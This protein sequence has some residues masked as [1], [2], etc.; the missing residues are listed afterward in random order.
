[1]KGFATRTT[2]LIFLLAFGLT[3][4]AWAQ[5]GK[6]AGRVT[7]AATGDPL[8]GVNVLLAGTTQGTITDID[9]YYT[10]LNVKPGTMTLQASFVGFTT[11]NVEGVRVFIDQTTTV[12]FVLQE[13]TVGLD[14]VVIT[15]SRP[16]VQRDV[17]NSQLN[18]GSDEI[19]ALPVASVSGVVGLQAGIQG[20]SVRGSGSDELAFMVN[21]LTLRDERDNSPYTAI[22]LSSIE[23][24]QV[25]T[26][27]FNA[28]YGNVRSGV[29]NVV[30]REGSPNRFSINGTMR[31]SAPTQKHF[32]ANA[33]D[34]NS[35]WIRPFIDP[36][37]AWTGTNNGAW[38]QSTRN[39]YAE[40]EGWI[41]ISESFLKDD[42]PT[43]DITPEALQEAFLWQHRKEFE[44]TV[45]DYTLDIGVGGPMPF[46]EKWGNARFYASLLRSQNMYMI[47][48]HTDRSENQSIQVKITSDLRPGM[49]LSVEG[50]I[51]ETS[52]TSDD[53]GGEPGIFST[54]TTIASQM[55][56]VSF[57]D[58]RIFST[59]YWAPTT[60][61]R[62]M[63]GATLT[64]AL[65]ASS[66]YEVRFSRFSSSYDTNPGRFRNTDPVV[67]FGGVGFDE[68]PFGFQPEPTFGVDGMRTGVGMSNARDTSEVVAY[69]LKA[70]FTNQVNRFM[71]VKTGFEYNITDS[72]VNYGRF[73]AFLKGSNNQSQWEELPIRAAAYGQTK[74]EFQGMVA[75]LGL[76]LDYADANTDWIEFD[77]FTSA[78]SARFAA[79]LDTLLDKSATEAQ[80]T[81]SPRLGV[82][83]PVTATSKLFFNYGHFR[84][85]PDP[86]NLYL[87]RAFSETGQ[88]SRV[89][90]PNIDLP[91]TISYELGYEQSL[92]DQFLIRVAGYYKDVSLQPFLVSYTSRDGQTDYST[93]EPN[94]F[95]DVRGFEITLSKNQGQWFQ[96]FI[97]YTYMVFTN[98]Y[99][100]FRNNSENPTVQREFENSD[101]ERRRA[102]DRPVPRPYARM[103]VLLRSPNDFGPALADQHLL[104]NWQVSLTGD[105]QRGAPLT[106]TGGGSIPGVLNNVR[107]P[108]TWDFEMRLSKSFNVPNGQLQFFVDITNLF[109]TRRMATNFSGTTL[110]GF[111][112]GTDF[113]SYMSSL[114]LPESPDYPNIPGGDQPGDY[115]EPGVAFQPMSGIQSRTI[116]NS[117]NVPD[118]NIIYYEFESE[119]Y[120]EFA[121]GAWQPVEGDRLEQVL[122]DKAYIDMPNMPF[123]SFLS[124]RDVYFGLR[125]SF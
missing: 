94:S 118:P 115:R 21:G 1:M 84:S 35:Y 101:A 124:P 125:F 49:K 54:P 119:S 17:S 63:I 109:N 58:T 56:R 79:G 29:V 26:G 83:F 121:S 46:S 93:S 38:D 16:V 40:F 96:G 113:T 65:S 53:R 64:H 95:E 8:P 85:M 37:V 39:Q 50:L 19:D 67:F 91:K 30:T 77:R 120:I 45:P 25:Q 104:G 123:L 42:D 32:G 13:S 51:G 23:E 97:N 90:N 41:A 70:D 44:I 55:N 122:D 81:L 69:N 9:G 98:G 57:I 43:N 107:L 100:G 78:F 7:D 3:S 62:N 31:Y 33:D 108:D 116:F 59:D 2:L 60:I 10:I 76:R 102:S 11:Q 24:V 15:A 82:S 52:A 36:D 89:A 106:W 12:D 87:I 14:E 103:N 75:N 111:V 73:D 80:I 117:A 68:A 88:I 6:I 27:G 92:L 112:N 74:L 47:P 4:V 72:R 114:H 71:Q 22:S 61:K 110:Y 5:S 99:F 86:N 28:E 20:L 34:P 48:L 66:F 105:W 18:V